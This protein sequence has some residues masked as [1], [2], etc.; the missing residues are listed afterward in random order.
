VEHPV[1][2]PEIFSELKVYVKRWLFDL[3]NNVD[4][5]LGK[6]TFLYD[7]LAAE[8]GAVPLRNQYEVTQVLIKRAVQGS[9]VSLFSWNNWSKYVKI[10]L[11]M[12]M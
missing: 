11:G 10:L 12:Y 5:R 1:E 2:V 6:A 4:I 7:D 8:Y 3:H 9:A